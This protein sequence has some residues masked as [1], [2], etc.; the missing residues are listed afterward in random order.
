MG[1]KK[2]FLTLSLLLCCFLGLHAQKKQAVS[3][4]Y[5]GGS[6]EIETVGIGTPPDP[7]VVAKSAAERTAAFEKF[8]KKNFKTVKVIDAKDYHYSM[9]DYY[10]VTIID[11]RPAELAPGIREVDEHGRM[12]RYARPQYFPLDFNRPVITIAEAGEDMGRRIGTKNDWYCLCLEDLALG[13]NASHP[14]FQGPVKV[15]LETSMQPTPAGALEFAEIMS[16]TLPA[17]T[18][19]FLMQTIN[20]T[21][22]MNG[23][24]TY[25][26]GMVSRPG[27]YLDSPETEVITGGKCAKSID[28]VAI[29]RHANWLTWGF[30]ASPAYMTETAKALFVNAVVYMKQFAGQHPIARKFNDGVATRDHIAMDKNRMSRSNWEAYNQSNMDF[31]RMVDSLKAV[32]KEQRAKGEEVDPNLAIYENFPEQKLITYRE[33]LMQMDRGDGLYKVFGTDEQAYKDY[34]DKNYGW[35]WCPEGSY[36]L[37]IDDEVRYL[38]IPNNDIR[39]LDKCISMLEK[40][41]PE[42]DIAET[43]LKRYTLCRFE[44]AKEWRD[45]Y[46]RYHDKL[47]FTEGGGYLWLVNTFENVPGN[48]YRVRLAEEEEAYM[49]Q[50]AARGNGR[51][52]PAAP[53]QLTDD[54]NPVYLQ[55]E[56][57]NT[58]K[59]KD[60][61]VFQKIHPGYHTYA[62]VPADEVFVVT[63][64]E[65][66]LPEG[67]KTVGPLYTPEASLLDASGTTVY[68]GTGEFRQSIE[69]EGEGEATVKVTYQCCNNNT[70]LV[71]ET[72]TFT[73]K[74]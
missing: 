49:A 3:V 26:I 24:Y 47:F 11:G 60:I 38:G 18:E 46:N 70:C 2:F 45:W 52:G 55:A 72:K 10:D 28:A 33:Y 73:V 59:G 13:W 63:T 31:N 41:D 34:Y 56:A 30:A 61:V 12:V 8:L 43:I 51:R 71:P 15:K 67:Y 66:T 69:G 62:V 14:I 32:I 25:R 53:V 27:G 1:M 74:L 19:M 6:P 9:S 36:S 57:V 64:V 65:I 17:E 5:V 20:Y 21:E 42:K 35:F 37:V 39:I 16:E 4:L 68:R 44:T 48:D 40:N 50:K 58:E 54:R 22:K 23:N 7:A 29:G